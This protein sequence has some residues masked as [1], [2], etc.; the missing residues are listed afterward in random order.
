MGIMGRAGAYPLLAF[1]D[2]GHGKHQASGAKGDDKA[3]NG[4]NNAFHR[5]SPVQLCIR[6]TISQMRYTMKVP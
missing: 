5:F 3:E 1:S 2:Q 4:V 6:E